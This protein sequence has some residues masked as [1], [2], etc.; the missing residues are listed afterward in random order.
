MSFTPEQA[1]ENTEESLREYLNRMFTNIGITFSQPSKFPK[2]KEMPYKPQ[3][4]D[5]H[6]FGD[7][8]DHD[9]NATITSEGFWGLTNL[10]WIKLGGSMNYALDV[11]KGLIPGT[12]LVNKFGRNSN[13]ALGTIEEIWSGS[14]TY[15]WPATALMTSISQTTD[16]GDLNG[17]TVEI[18][19]L[20]ANYNLVV[21]N[22]TLG[23]PSTTVVT[24]GT[25]LIRCF[26]M[27]VS[28]D[29]V[30]TSDIRVHNAGETQDYAIISTGENQTT[31]AIYTVPAGKTAYMTN[32]WAHHNPATDKDP[33]SNAIKLWARDN[34][35]NYESQLKHV[36]GL[37][38]AGGFQ[39]SFEPYPIYTEKTDLYITASPVT[40]DSDV[41]AGFDLYLV[42]NI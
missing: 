22:A 10:G 20:D 9:Y 36:V 32:Y 11:S 31:M 24:L 15:V 37:P 23:T 13:V 33:P 39:H 7:P 19:G 26:R 18:Q 25:A 40:K 12:T 42:D 27:K 8:A 34:A 4:G 21:Q 17:A 30:S 28:A 29:F 38:T 3:I 35:N 1:P 14:A 6:Y 16:Q 2:R 5:V 41:S